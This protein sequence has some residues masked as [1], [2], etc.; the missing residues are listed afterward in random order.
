MK[1]TSNR[2]AFLAAAV[3]SGAALAGCS[4]L[5]STPDT[6]T[7]ASTDTDTDTD[8]TTSTQ[9]DANDT[10][11]ETE[12]TEAEPKQNYHYT[13]R[14]EV[15]D[16][17]ENLDRWGVISGEKT[18]ETEDVYKGSQS[19]RIQNP[20]GDG[21]GI[22]KAFPDGLDLTSRDLSIA[23]KIERPGAAKLAVEV[24]APARSDHLVCR[25]YF[26]E[27]MDDWMRV[28]LGYTGLRG[29]PDLSNVQELRII[30]LSDGEPINFV[31]DD[32][33]TAP[34]SVDS[35]RVI[36]SFDDVRASHYDI[37]FNEL[38]KRGWP[39]MESVIPDEV[40]ASG[41]LTTGQL[42]EMRGAGWDIISHPQNGTPLPELSED[43]QRRVIRDAKE[44]LDLKGFRD[45][46]RFMSIPY[47]SFDGTTLDIIREEHEYGFT[48]G[49]CPSSIPP[50]NDVAISTVNGRDLNGAA[51]MINLAAQFNQLTVVNFP[52]IGPDKPV[53]KEH[54]TQLLDI[55]EEWG[56]NLQVTTASEL[57]AMEQG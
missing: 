11:T 34:K 22:F 57:L 7:D 55:I 30:V 54:F 27:P 41:A 9:T 51:R 17:F 26:P 42:R 13:D 35:G 39:A 19:A 24:I 18:A 2:R 15:L 53:S 46:K 1:R 3:A 25:R 5:S 29:N 32:L 4:E 40:N 33:R 8:T 38:Q 48:F 47:G 36:L 49:A 56:D 28:D 52:A 14:G 10:G 16:D 45:G 12:T 21:A 31:V 6:S 43:E 20:A 44:Y 50:V 23:A 37:A